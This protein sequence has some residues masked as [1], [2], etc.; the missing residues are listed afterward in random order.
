MGNNPEEGKMRMDMSLKR[1]DY[2]DV[3]AKLEDTPLPLSADE[4]I[5]FDVLD[6]IYRSLCAILYNYVPRSGHPGGSISAGRILE[7][8]VFNSLEYDIGDPDRKDSDIIV[9][10]AGHKALGLYALWALR[11]EILRLQRPEILPKNIRS[12]LRLEDLLGFRRNPVT[13]TPLFKMYGAKALDG[14][15]TPATPFIRI[16]TGASGVGLAASIG[17][18]FG[19]MD[20]F[21]KKAPNIHI[22]EGEGGLTS[23]RTVEAIAGASAASLRNAIVHVDWNQA[24]IDTNHVCRENGR[25]GDYV[26]WDPIE[27]FLLHDWNVIFV[28]DGRNFQQIILAHRLATAF[29]ND[30]PTAVVYRTVK[31]WQYGIEGRA[32][33]GAG[34]ELCSEGFCH[35]IAQL[36]NESQRV[37]PICK[38]GEQLCLSGDKTDIIKREECFWE[39]LLIVR[40]V[41]QKNSSVCERLVDR[42][43]SARSS[44]NRLKR[45]PRK[46]AP[47]VGNVYQIATSEPVVPPELLLNTGDKTTLRYELFRALHY[48]N[49]VSLGAFLASSADL[50][51]STSLSVLGEGFAEGYFNASTNPNSR[52][53][54]VG[55][56]CEDAITGVVSGV[57]SFGQHIGVVSSYAAFLAPLGHL[58]VRL[59]AIGSQARQREYGDQYHPVILVCA[60]AG[61]ITGEDGP[62]HADPQALQ[63]L[64]GNFPP[65]I[66]ITLTPWDPREIWP[67]LT[68]TLEQRPAIIAPFV[69]RPNVTVVNREKLGLAPVEATLDGM[70]LLRRP[71]GKP[72]GT[73][74]IQGSGVANAFISEALPL[75]DT[76]NIELWVYY[77]SSAELFDQLAPEKKLSIFPE[78]RAYEAIGITGFTLP[79]LFRWVKSNKGRDLSLYPFK[80]GNYL[81]S[82]QADVVLSEAGLDG[83]S[84]FDA[85]KR[86]VDILRSEGLAAT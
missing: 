9:L 64:Q 44:L 53:L 62:T 41:I 84:Q 78:E 59:H 34:H 35:A 16:A 26:Q 10:A 29:N 76:A 43:Q 47:I 46:S 40:E 20:F 80:N 63:L 37:L 68:K 42:V 19:A 83:K 67:L 55:G 24:S 77:V 15:P 48:Y 8:L 32:A 56:I 14:H 52:L 17:L 71:N 70:Y 23:G 60:H 36:T 4:Q 66:A 33:H 28:P 21:G 74:V 57:S 85:I 30:Q 39:A 73:V 81:G 3:S 13:T 11:D 72:Q 86:Y 2:I 54:A 18:A 7:S 69:T 12:R 65:N 50:V 6:T 45:V 31:G 61:I 5:T 22:V 38:R 25:P 82:G 49:D 1:N 27:L 79:T 51:G 75:L 58:S